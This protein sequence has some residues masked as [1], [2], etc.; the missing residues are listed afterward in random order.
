MLLVLVGLFSAVLG[1]SQIS[2]W[3]AAALI[4]LAAA[5][6]CSEC[7]RTRNRDLRGR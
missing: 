6:I 7:S 4:P 5:V 3:G 2:N 1:L